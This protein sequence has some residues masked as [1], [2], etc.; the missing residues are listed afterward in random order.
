MFFE[1][2][3]RISDNRSTSNGTITC[4]WYKYLYVV[5]YLEQVTNTVLTEIV[6]ETFNGLV[7]RT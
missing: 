7:L 6:M 3:E 5:L 2:A 4:S 1:K